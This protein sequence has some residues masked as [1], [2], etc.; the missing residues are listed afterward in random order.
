MSR[1]NKFLMLKPLLFVK[2]V[3]AAVLISA[4]LPLI[5]FSRLLAF[6]RSRKNSFPAS[7]EEIDRIIR[8][9]GLVTRCRVF[10]IRDNCLKRSLLYYYFLLE[11]G[12]E[13]VD[14]VIGVNKTS[15]K[16]T[17]HSWLLLD[18]KP[19]PDSAEDLAAYKIIFSTGDS[20]DFKE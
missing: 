6:I 17:A 19:F 7:A 20:F 18:K 15:E 3:S 1:Q 8:M 16:I 2:V 11:Y 14:L 10:I 12:Y 5:R 4:A 13:D 9:V